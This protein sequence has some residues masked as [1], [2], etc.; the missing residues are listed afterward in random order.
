MTGPIGWPSKLIS[1]YESLNPKKNLVKSPFEYNSLDISLEK[2]R[3]PNS[4]EVELNSALTL[5]S[6]SVVYSF[7]LKTPE[8]V[9]IKPPDK[10]LPF[11]KINICA[12]F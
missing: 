3:S 12:G 5:S 9:L 10:I 6:I 1:R 8:D 2:A 4:E 11:G 7:A